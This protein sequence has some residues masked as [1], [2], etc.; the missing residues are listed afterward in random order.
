M[1]PED[2][3]E[4]ILSTAVREGFV[5]ISEA[6][7]VLDVSIETVRR[8]IN[9]LCMENKVTK[10]RGGACPVKR[11]LRRDAEYM[12][13]KGE[14][15]H[16]KFAIGQKAAQLIRNG[17]VVILD[18]GVSI[19][20]IAA[21]VSGVRDVTFITNSVPTMS[22][23]LDKFASEEITGRGILIGGE[24]DTRNRFTRGLAAAEALEQYSANLAFISC[25]AV[26]AEAV[27]SYSMDESCFSRRIMQRASSSVLIAES[28]KFGKNSVQ[29]F[30]KVTSFSKIIT[31]S[32]KHF[33]DEI[34][35]I[36]ETSD[37]EL[38][39]AGRLET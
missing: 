38:I 13:R 8:D 37:T 29:S 28:E 18:C 9:L 39:L 35:Q 22:I 2:R 26:S 33:P 32:E 12:L 31:D 17:D 25:T 30:A 7:R 5:S 20:M 4:Y 11:M 36:L 10:V 21:T 16:A 15:P 24:M 1:K 14:N 27:S 34:L 23:L 19:Q 3:L 6:S